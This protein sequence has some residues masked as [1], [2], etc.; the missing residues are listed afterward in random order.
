VIQ[1][2]LSL[3]EVKRTDL[4]IISSED[5]TALDASSRRAAPWLLKHHEAGATLASVCTG[6]FLLAETGLL[7]GKR[8]TTHWGFAELFRKRYPQVELR[9]ESLITDEGSLAGVGL[10]PI[11]T[12]PFTWWK[13]FA[14]LTLQHNVGNPS[15]WIL[16]GHLNFPMPSLSIRSS[17]KTIRSSRLK[18]LLKKT[19]LSSLTWMTWLP[20]L[21]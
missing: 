9:P 5:L 20:E 14:V 4:I 18:H 3:D 17:T 13:G 2:H 10:F 1:P 15:C 21:E 8:A 11:L 6:A 7:D 19:T 16:D 12:Y